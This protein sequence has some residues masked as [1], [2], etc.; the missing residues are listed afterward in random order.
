MQRVQK[1]MSANGYCSRRKAEDF[2]KNGKVKVNGKVIHLGD[3][4][5]ETD[6]IKINDVVLKKIPK[7]YVKFHKPRGCVTAVYDRYE[8]TVMDYIKIKERVFPVGRLDKDTTGLLLLTNDGD[9]ANEITHPSNE[10]KKTYLVGLFTDIDET[11]LKKLEQGVM[12]ED[13]KTAP[14]KVKIL[15]EKLVEVEI[16]EGK[17]RII[18]RMFRA[19]GYEV[20][21]LKRVKIGK[22]NLGELPEGRYAFLNIKPG[23]KWPDIF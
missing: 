1:I 3:Q 20:N 13:G 11:K 21:F 8:D 7:L 19:I 12:L 10:I 16:H 14:A 6:E 17:N 15:H 2:I 18:R 5:L 4:A 9:F 22:L 23:E